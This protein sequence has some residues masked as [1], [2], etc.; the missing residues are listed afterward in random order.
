MPHKRMDGQAPVWMH[1]SV[2]SR[3]NEDTSGQII[4]VHK[5]TEQ[6]FP[7]PAEFCCKG[8]DEAEIHGDAAKLKWKIPPVVL[9]LI[10]HVIQEQLLVNLA[11]GQDNAAEK[12]QPYKKLPVCFSGKKVSRQHS[13]QEA[14]GHNTDMKSRIRPGRYHGPCCF[15]NKFFHCDYLS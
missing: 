11:C 7:L 8:Q 9:L 15:Y 4:A 2:R 12:Q 6:P 10:Y 5:S 3:K 1:H 13:R 14:R